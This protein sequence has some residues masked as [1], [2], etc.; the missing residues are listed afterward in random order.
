MGKVVLVISVL[1]LN[2]ISPVPFRNLK[3]LS[4]ILI[5]TLIALTVTEELSIIGIPFLF[6]K[7]NG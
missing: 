1:S 6:A 5:T 7:L 3:D 2:K 4:C